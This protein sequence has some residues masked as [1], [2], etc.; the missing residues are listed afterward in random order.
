MRILYQLFFFDMASV[1]NIHLQKA[2]ELAGT[3][4]AEARPL[5]L[6]VVPAQVLLDSLSQTVQY[7]H[8]GI[9][10]GILTWA[11]G[12]RFKWMLGFVLPLR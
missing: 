7:C 3:M 4:P 10:N 11:V 6:Q 2:C 1:A 9:C 8:C 5:L 12:I